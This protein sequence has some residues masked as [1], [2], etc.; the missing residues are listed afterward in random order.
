M[1]NLKER[2]ESKT[3]MEDET[4]AIPATQGGII[5]WINGKKIPAANGMAIILYP[6]A[7]IKFITILL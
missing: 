5:T 2:E 4:M 3:Q 7:Q 1:W 6:K